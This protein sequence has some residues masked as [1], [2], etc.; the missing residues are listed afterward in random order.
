MYYN[1]QCVKYTGKHHTKGYTK[2]RKAEQKCI[3]YG[4]A[5]PVKSSV[6]IELQKVKNET[7]N[8]RKLS[9]YQQ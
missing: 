4:E 7:M 5:C 3:H 6:A 8:M 2:A 9:V 1:T